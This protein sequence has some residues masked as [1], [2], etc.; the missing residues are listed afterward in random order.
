MEIEDAGSDE[1]S[2]ARWPSRIVDLALRLKD[3]PPGSAREKILGELWRLVH[4][5]LER[6]I[7][8]HSVFSGRTES[9]EIRDLA[10]DKALELLLGI[11]GKTWDPAAS[12]PA[13][14]CSFL[15]R[16]ARNAAVDDLRRLQRER[17]F[18]DT[19]TRS[20]D[21]EGEWAIRDEERI[22][23]SP[24]AHAEHADAISQCSGRLT[25]KARLVW[26]LRVFHEMSSSEIANHPDVATTRAAVD[27]MLL[28]CRAWM[29]ECMATKGFDLREIPAGTFARLWR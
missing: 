3:L 5:V 11:E 12:T 9:E 7:R 8:S 1:S 22:H 2:A 4:L 25:P 20:M 28:R 18:S 15:V 17:R 14:V 24:V 13:Q 27:T 16:V 23:F 10:A 29:R 21:E 19:L 6:L 26:V